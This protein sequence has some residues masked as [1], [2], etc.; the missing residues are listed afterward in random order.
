MKVSQLSDEAF[1]PIIEQFE[2]PDEGE[3]PL[4]Y[5]GMTDM[6]KWIE[7]NIVIY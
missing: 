7:Q 4:I 2:P 6:D 1:Y 3:H 5:N